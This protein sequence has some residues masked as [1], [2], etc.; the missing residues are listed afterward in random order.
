MKNA[1]LAGLLTLGFS[2]VAVADVAPKITKTVPPETKRDAALET[3]LLAQLDEEDG[4]PASPV[5]YWYNRVDLNEDGT[6]EVVMGIT[7]R[8]V[9]GSGGC[10]TFVFQKEGDAYRL[11]TRISV[12]RNPLVVSEHRTNGWHDLILP[13]G[14]GGIEPGHAILKFDGKTYPDNPTVEP[15]EP[16]KKPVS[17]TSYLDDNTDGIVIKSRK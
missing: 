17:G 13:V 12:A 6:P 15:A 14:G 3:A 11:V 10:N 4:T 7:A 1:L 5:T 16:L 8:S 2:F 9:C